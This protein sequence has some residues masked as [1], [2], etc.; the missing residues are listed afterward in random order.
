MPWGFPWYFCAC[1][2]TILLCEKM[3]LTDKEAVVCEKDQNNIYER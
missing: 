3:F 2:V 1:R